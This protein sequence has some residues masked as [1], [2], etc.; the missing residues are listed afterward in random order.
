M[1]AGY[2]DEMHE[3]FRSELVYRAE[4][5]PLECKSFLFREMFLL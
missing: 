5:I 2:I 1:S 3:A 4:E